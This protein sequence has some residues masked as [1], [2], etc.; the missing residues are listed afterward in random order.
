[1]IYLSERRP[2][3]QP[4]ATACGASWPRS[5]KQRAACWRLPPAS[6]PRI[7]GLWTQRDAGSAR[8][9]KQDLVD[10][11]PSEVVGRRFRVR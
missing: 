1:V 10:P 11:R 6:C 9:R 7:A 8:R 3:R 2:T 4:I 5:R